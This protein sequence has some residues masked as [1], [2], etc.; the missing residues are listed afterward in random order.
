VYDDG[1]TIAKVADFGLVKS[2]ELEITS[3]ET[4]VKGYFND[5]ELATEGFTSYSMEHEIYALTKL[6]YFV[7]TGKI[8]VSKIKNASHKSF[9]ACGLNPD[10]SK[11]YVNCNSIKLAFQQI[12]SENV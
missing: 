6:L 10:K 4:E 7:L 9:V 3:L 5:P 12:S 8:N 1:T 2:P 11:R